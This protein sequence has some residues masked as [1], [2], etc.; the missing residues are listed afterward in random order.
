MTPR[1]FLSTRPGPTGFGN[2]KPLANP[3]AMGPPFRRTWFFVCDSG[4]G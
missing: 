3:S 2:D 4:E 1:S